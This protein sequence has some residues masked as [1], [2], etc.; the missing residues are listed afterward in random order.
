MSSSV[1]PPINIPL[2]TPPSINRKRFSSNIIDSEFAEFDEKLIN[3]L[4]WQ[5]W[6]FKNETFWTSEPTVFL[7][8]PTGHPRSNEIITKS[9][10]IQV[11]WHGYKPWIPHWASL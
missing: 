11:L 5:G 3:M 10:S 7:R 2:A 9:N 1:S 6:H 8:P 4:L